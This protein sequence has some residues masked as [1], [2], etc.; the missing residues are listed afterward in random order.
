M[1]DSLVSGGISGHYLDYM[2]PDMEYA[3]H[4]FARDVI[5]RSGKLGNSTPLHPLLEK[6]ESI[7]IGG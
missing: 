6:R 5:R 2:S 1:Q 3:P 7:A 4:I